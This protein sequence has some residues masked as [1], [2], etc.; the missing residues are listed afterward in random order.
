MTKDH[1]LPFSIDKAEQLLPDS[2]TEAR[3]A[4]LGTAAVDVVKAAPR[5]T[6][7][8]ISRLFPAR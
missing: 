6:N 1:A 4:Q 3:T 2:K 8:H 7:M 5:L